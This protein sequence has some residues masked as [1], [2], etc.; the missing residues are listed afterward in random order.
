MI[1]IPCRKDSTN[2]VKTCCCILVQNNNI[3]VVNGF[4]VEALSPSKQFFSHVGTNVIIVTE[5]KN[6]HGHLGELA[7]K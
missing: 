5:Y 3:L 7:N 4:G 6:K 2:I 1:H